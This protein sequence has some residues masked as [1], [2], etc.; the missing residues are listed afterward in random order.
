MKK[1]VIALM[2]VA[3]VSA[4]AFA[5]DSVTYDGGK[6]GAVTF[7]HKAHSTKFECSKCHEG[8]PAKIAVEGKKQGHAV[9]KDC[10]KANGAT[11]S[12]S[13]CHVK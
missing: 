12:C 13:K 10:H 6:K 7:D 4:V 5:A 2:L 1:I 9:C 3:F 8:T 11:T